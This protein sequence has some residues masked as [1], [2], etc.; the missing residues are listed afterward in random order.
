M[1]ADIRIAPSSFCP[2]TREI[3]RKCPTN[4]WKSNPK[5]ILSSNP[6]VSKRS[7]QSIP[8]IH[9][10]HTILS[11]SQLWITKHQTGQTNLDPTSSILF[12][13]QVRRVG[14]TSRPNQRET[15]EYKHRCTSWKL[16]VL[17]GRCTHVP[18]SL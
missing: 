2:N 5:S 4:Q 11:I 13:R 8:A 14:H 18:R 17:Y 16:C 7:S 10:V 6:T 15:R 3:D 1:N 9:K 12:T